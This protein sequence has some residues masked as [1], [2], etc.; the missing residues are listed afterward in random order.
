[1]PTEEV[2]RLH[3]TESTIKK[4]FAYSGNQCAMPDCLTPLVD[5]TGAML[6]KIAHIHGAEKG[7]ARFDKNM[8]NEQRR[9]FDNLFLVCGVCH[10]IIDYKDNVDTYT[11]DKLKKIKKTHE[12]RFRRAERALLQKYTDTTQI[13][14]PTYPTTLQKLADCYD[15]PQLAN[16]SDELE[17]IRD[18]INRLKELPLQER[19]FALSVAE[20]MRRQ[21][22]EKLPVDDVAGAFQ[23]SQGKLKKHMD[24]LRHHGLGDIDEGHNP[25]EYF[26]SLGTRKP[27]DVNPW[28]EILDFCERMNLNTDSFIHDLNFAQYD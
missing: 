6:G 5:K 17:G 4:L 26:V 12:D 10:D 15:M 20:R 25:G 1:M 13:V 23:I 19:E 21:K 9:A 18:F 8:T 3:P 27:W 14:Q 22:E 7:A 24:L 2:K 11:P 16:D 28:I